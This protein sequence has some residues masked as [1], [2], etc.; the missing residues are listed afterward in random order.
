MAAGTLTSFTPMP[1]TLFFEDLAIGQTASLMR[2]V[3]NGDVHL[4]A[5]V[6]GDGA[7]TVGEGL[8]T[9]IDQLRITM[10]CV[11]AGNLAALRR[12]PLERGA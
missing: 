1:S 6:S 11:G 4:F 5:A 8:Q 3:M 2:T 10:F 12:T 7:A 9:F